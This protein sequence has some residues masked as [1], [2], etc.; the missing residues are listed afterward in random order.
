MG[1]KNKRKF[2][3]LYTL[4]FVYHIFYVVGDYKK[5]K[6]ILTNQLETFLKTFRIIN[7]QNKKHEQET[8]NYQQQKNY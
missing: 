7:K 8:L 2:F 6:K 1:K 5:V 3:P 4:L